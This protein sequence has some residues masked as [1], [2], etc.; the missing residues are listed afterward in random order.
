[1]RAEVCFLDPGSVNRSLCHPLRVAASSDPVSSVTGPGSGCHVSCT[2]VIDAS[3]FSQ[4][5]PVVGLWLVGKD[6]PTLSPRER[7]LGWLHRGTGGQLGK[8]TAPPEGSG[9]PPVC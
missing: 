9:Q 2:G 8:H 3:G 1:M 6:G 5:Q 4:V 7:P